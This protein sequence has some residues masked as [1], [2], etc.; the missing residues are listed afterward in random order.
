MSKTEETEKSGPGRPKVQLSSSQW[1]TAEQMAYIQCTRDEI[2]GVLGIDHDTFTRCIK[3]LGFDNFSAWFKKHSSGGKMSLRRNQ[4]KM[5]EKNPTMAIWL[6][7]QYLGQK[8][9]A[10]ISGDIRVSKA[11]DTSKMSKEEYIKFMK[12]QLGNS[13]N[14]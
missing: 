7:K 3:D 6:G 13:D 11:F 12:E 5:S 10:D 2:S 1:K 8:D 4:F 14:E 9:Q